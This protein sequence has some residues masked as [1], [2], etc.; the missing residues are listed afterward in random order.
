MSSPTLFRALY[1]LPT[2]FYTLYALLTLFCAFYINLRPLYNNA[3]SVSV[4]S[5][6][7]HL[8]RLRLRWASASSQPIQAMDL[9][10]KGTASA[11][12]IQTMG[13]REGNDGNKQR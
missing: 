2:P 10:S 1:A 9:L 8:R 6:S 11:D 3:G 12:K 7:F 4:I 5:T 13:D